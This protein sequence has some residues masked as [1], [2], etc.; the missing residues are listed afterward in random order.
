[1]RRRDR[2]HQ[3]RDARR[4]ETG[5]ALPGLLR[6]RAGVRRDRAMRR[7]ALLAGM[8]G[9]AP[10]LPAA[11][12]APVRALAPS[13]VAGA[14]YNTAPVGND[15][16]NVTLDLQ[17]ARGILQ[18]LSA[19]KFDRAWAAGLEGL[20]AGRAAIKDSRRPAE[21]F[22]HDLAAAFDEKARPTLFDF[23]QV[24]EDRGRW[25]DLLAMIASR[26]DELTQL[27]SQRARALL[28]G[29]RPVTVATAILLT[30]GLP[31]RA[32]HLA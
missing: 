21:V 17:A 3:P 26:Q 28:P 12:P 27:A 5:R 29:D 7:A 11:A 19:D 6:H 15:V 16:V 20:P 8:L 4:R 13:G 31:G 9:L 32:D 2:N 30:F 22:E 24:R 10:T 1:R 18:V 14:P 25:K 23:H